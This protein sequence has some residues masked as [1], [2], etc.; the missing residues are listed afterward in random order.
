MSKIPA[1]SV[2]IPTYN[3]ANALGLTLEHLAQQSL[4][5]DQFEVFIVDDGSEDETSR[6]VASQT[7]PFR[8]EYLRQQNRGAA[9]ARNVG[10]NRALADLIVFVDADVIPDTCFLEQHIHLHTGPA[11][12]LIVGRVRTWPGTPRPWYDIRIDPDVGMDYG[13]HQRVLPFYMALAGNLSLTKRAFDEIGG[14]DEAFPAA[15]CEETEF[16]YRASLLGYRLSYQP[17]AIGYHNHPRTLHQRCQ[18]QRIH[19]RSMALLILKHP[20][21]QTIVFGVDELMPLFQEPRS[22]ERLLRR[23]RASL[24]G[25]HLVRCGLSVPLSVLDHYRILPRIAKVLFW[26]LSLGWRFVG[27]REGLQRYADDVRLSGHN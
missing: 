5:T 1:V 21:L 24:F 26:R 13:D 16:A 12:Q 23:M 20:E 11:K 6:I 25:S 17:S 14:F 9:A 22:R 10:V 18:Q 19:M 3:R 27:F 4:P 7:A 2:V 8:L 15:G